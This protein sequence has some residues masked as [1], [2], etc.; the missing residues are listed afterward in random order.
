MKKFHKREVEIPNVKFGKYPD[1]GET[2]LPYSSIITRT[3]V[4]PGHALQSS[5]TTLWVPHSHGFNLT[6]GNKI[7]IK[8]LENGCKFYEV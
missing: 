5:A 2:L 8:I 6:E 4:P 3:W 1:F 7:I